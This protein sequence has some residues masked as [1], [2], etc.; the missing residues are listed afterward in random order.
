MAEEFDNS[1]LGLMNRIR[2]G[3]KARARQLVRKIRT[4][5]V[6]VLDVN[7]RAFLDLQGELRNFLIQRKL[8]E[9]ELPHSQDVLD[10]EEQDEDAD[11]DRGVPLFPEEGP[12]AGYTPRKVKI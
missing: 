3:F 8:W 7:E 1:P 6:E 12:G 4:D 10:E 11:I 2:K 5:L 9:Q